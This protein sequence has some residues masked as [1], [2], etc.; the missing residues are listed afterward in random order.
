MHANQIRFL[1]HKWM[2]R[3][4]DLNRKSTILKNQNNQ[5]GRKWGD[6][7]ESSRKRRRMNEFWEKMRETFMR[8]MQ[9]PGNNIDI[10]G[11][12]SLFGSGCLARKIKN[13]FWK[14]KK[15]F[16]WIK[17]CCFSKSRKTLVESKTYFEKWKCV[18]FAYHVPR[19]LFAT[20]VTSPSLLLAIEWGWAP[21]YGKC[22]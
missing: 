12:W 3:C 10:K 8:V 7:Y 14:V 17:C 6:F 9:A 21:L 16:G 4:T 11:E 5:F 18:P 15:N 13:I 2:P 22:P 20:A 1:E 19:F